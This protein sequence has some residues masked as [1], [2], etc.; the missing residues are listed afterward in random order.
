MYTPLKEKGDIIF[1]I[2]F[3]NIHNVPE[4]FKLERRP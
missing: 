4:T 1:M 3:W 2:E